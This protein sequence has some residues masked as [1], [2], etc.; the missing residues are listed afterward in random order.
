M[1]RIRRPHNISNTTATRVSSLSRTSHQGI[2]CKRIVQACRKREAVLAHQLNMQCLLPSHNN[3]AT[4]KGE[5]TA[6]A[7]EE[8][9]AK[10]GVAK[11]TKSRNKDTNRELS[12]TITVRRD[13]RHGLVSA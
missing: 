7:G 8:T 12:D 6:R 4:R 1:P 13:S 2:R 9:N 5:G 11:V 10:G 3:G